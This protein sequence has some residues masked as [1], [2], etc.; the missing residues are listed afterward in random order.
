MKY[1]VIAL[2]SFIP[3]QLVYIMITEA[4]ENFGSKLDKL[5]LVMKFYR[6]ALAIACL[7]AAIF[8]RGA[9]PPVLDMSKLQTS[10][11]VVECKNSGG[12]R[13]TGMYKMDSFIYKEAFSNVFGTGPSGPCFE[14]LNGHMARIVWLP[15]YDNTE[16][17][18]FQISDVKT[19]RIYGLTAEKSYERHKKAIENKTWFYLSKVALFL[20]ALQ[21]AFWERANK[22]HKLFK[23]KSKKPNS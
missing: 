4:Y 9:E 14:E 18:M 7:I 10:E 3:I 15:I 11:G 21:F 6:Y 22:F 19:S 2:I 13:S 23:L 16:R 20:L 5:H 1:L 8:W 17:L 12:K